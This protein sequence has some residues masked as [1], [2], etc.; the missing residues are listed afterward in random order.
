MKV[1]T[2]KVRG[3]SNIEVE[4]GAEIETIEV[5]A[6]DVEIKSEGKINSLK[7]TQNVKVNDKVVEKGKEIKIEDGKVKEIKDDKKED[8]KPTTPSTGGGGGGGGG[9]TTRPDPKLD[10]TPPEEPKLKEIEIEVG[11]SIVYVGEGD[12]Y[13]DIQ[14]LSPSDV[15]LSY[16][17]NNPQIVKINEKTGEMTGISQGQ[18]TITVTASKSGYRTKTVVFT[19]YVIPEPIQGSFKATGNVGIAPDTAG[20]A[21]GK[22]YA[23]YKLVAEG[24]DISLASDNVEYIKVKVGDGEWKELTANTDTTLWFNVEAAHGMRSYEIKTKDGKVYTAT[25]NWDKEIKSA[26]W[27]ATNREGDHEGVTY[28]EYKLMDGTKPVSLKVGEV[29]LVASKDES[30]WIALEPNTDSTLWFN[31]AHETG[32]YDFFLVTNEGTMYKAT[33]EW[34]KPGEE[35]IGK[36]STYKFSYTMP[37]EVTEGEEIAIN[38][39]FA[40]DVR[41]DFGYDRVRFKFVVTGPEGANVTFKATDS[42]GKEHTFT[43]EGVWGPAEGFT[44]PAEYT[45]TTNWKVTFDKAG[46]YTITFKLIN[47]DDKEAI[48]AEGFETITVVEAPLIPKEYHTYKFNIDGLAT[49]YIVSEGLVEPGDADFEGMIPVKLSI[50]VGQ[51]NDKAYEG[52]VR[53]APVGADNLQL[54]AKD[55][56]GNWYDINVVGWGPGEGF[57]IILDA[58]T[59]IY[60]IATAAFD[61]NVTLNL[62]D[63]TGG[64]G[65]ID[66]IIVT[67]EVAVKAVEKPS[68]H[69]ANVAT[70]EDFKAA[71][72]DETKTLINLTADFSTNEKILIDRAVTINGNNHTITFVNDAEGW[73]GNYVLH[74][75]KA[76]GVTIKDIK[77]TGGDAALY[78]NGSEVTLEGTVDITGNEFGG[79][80]VSQG[81]DVTNLPK[82]TVTGA[83]TYQ[84]PDSDIKPVIWI[85]GRQTN[86]GWVVAEGLYEEV[87]GKNPANNGDQYYFFDKDEYAKIIKA[88]LAA[89]NNYLTPEAYKYSEAPEALEEQLALL[90]LDVG[91]GGDYTNLDKTA[92]GGKNRK[93]AVFYDLNKNKPA[94]GYDLST[95]TRYFNDMVATRLVTE[96]SMD[97]VNNAESI[98][99]L[100]GISFVTMLLDRFNAVNYQTH[101]DIPVETKKST[102][103]DLVTRYDNLGSDENCNAVLQKLLDKRPSDG[104]ARSQATTDALDTALTEVVEDETTLE[105]FIKGL[106]L[107]VKEDFEGLDLT[108]DTKIEEIS[109]TGRMADLFTKMSELGE[110]YSVKSIQGIEDYNM[111]NVKAAIVNLMMAEGRTTL[112]DLDNVTISIDVVYCYGVAEQT[113]TYKF[114][115]DISKL[116]SGNGEAEG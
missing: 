60:V 113:A 82:L 97:L 115:F 75:Y 23:E 55:T 36:P 71:L 83:I 5:E 22:I 8:K 51:T 40:T 69:I 44:I 21:A 110:G 12:H 47:L 57:P 106:T 16:K 6:K 43:N 3:K 96:E 1:E 45:A 116:K 28:V 58:K 92:D 30:K 25:L 13:P 35:P 95:L 88:A 59:E 17:S 100:N 66:N 11:N 70:L 54:W 94:E 15:Q 79:I 84:S 80:E 37:R 86:D 78:A 34:T 62:V 52:K 24:K 108:L 114:S 61:G 4:K 112:E 87:A 76:T 103:Q 93:T 109:G 105:T 111:V 9:G 50:V 19:V 32:N 56:E 10:P 46:E 14:K 53:V 33:L 102:L 89:V 64:Y 18:T 39:T 65:A 41:G 72:A 81:K 74:V 90:G 48:I 98:E 38:V 63:V 91:E 104:Y 27:E 49:E 31:K 7:T 20:D 77:L 73:Q 107:D 85:D 29:K 68:T 101:S 99:D 2:V 67:Q 26:T 42:K